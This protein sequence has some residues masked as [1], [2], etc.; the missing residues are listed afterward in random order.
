MA[1]AFGMADA[2]IRSMDSGAP[3]DQ[4]LYT[5]LFGGIA[6]KQRDD[7]KGK[8]ESPSWVTR[9]LMIWQTV[10]DEYSRGERQAPTWASRMWYVLFLY[11]KLLYALRLTNFPAENL[12]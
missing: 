8:L 12:L 3:H 7:I 9:I 11:D 6:G 10:I 2:A 1:G 5:N 4:A